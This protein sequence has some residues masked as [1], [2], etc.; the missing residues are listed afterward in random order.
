MEPIGQR[1]I[2]V[3]GNRHQAEAEPDSFAEKKSGDQ[4]LVWERKEKIINSLIFVFMSGEN[5]HYCVIENEKIAHLFA[6]H[7]QP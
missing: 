1:V 4:P 7:P 6:C 2:P 5:S 3:A